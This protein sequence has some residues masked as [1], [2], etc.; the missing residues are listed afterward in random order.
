V[1]STASTGPGPTA[2]TDSSDSAWKHCTYPDLSKKHSL[3]C[4]YCGKT[5]TGGITR[6]KYHL[7]RVPKSNVE[8]MLNSMFLEGYISWFFE[9]R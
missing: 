2:G 3:R 1:S 4:N 6:I 8:K 9:N 7:G 5:Y